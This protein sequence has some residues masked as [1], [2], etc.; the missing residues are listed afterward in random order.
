MNQFLLIFK[1]GGAGLGRG[2]VL[3]FASIK[4]RRDLGTPV[5][6]FKRWPERLES[7]VV[8]PELPGLPVN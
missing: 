7:R 6:A 2:S 3:E 4:T 1:R 5:I 8:E